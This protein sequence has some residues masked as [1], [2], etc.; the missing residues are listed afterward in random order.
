MK[1]RWL[2]VP[3]MLALLAPH[4][5]A[6]TPPLTPTLSPSRG[7]GQGEGELQIKLGEAKPAAKGSVK[8]EA[9][10][11]ILPEMDYVDLVYL[12][13]DR[14]VLLRLHLR[15]N[16]R[17]YTDRWDKYMRKLYTHLDKNDDG[18][19]T[20]AE[21]E[22][23]PSI[24]FLQ[25]HLGGQI[26]LPYQGSAGRMAQFDR[27]N[28]GKVSL[29]EFKDYYRRSAFGPLQL[30]ST[31]NTPA[32]EAATNSIFKYLD[33]NKDG[34]LSADEVARAEAALHRFDLDENEML[35][36]AELTPGGGDANIFFNPFQPG[37]ATL[38][39]KV[40]FLEVRRDTVAVV[41]QQIVRHYDSDDNGKL[42]RGES[43]L[44]KALFDQLDANRDG[45]L[46]AKELVAFLRRNA[47]LEVIGRIGPLPQEGAVL[48]LLHRSGVPIR[49]ARRADIFNPSQRAMPLAKA[50]QRKDSSAL[51][52]KLGD[53]QVR[54]V[55]GADASFGRFP[56][57]F[58][59]NQFRQAD[60]GNKGV[61]D[62]KQAQGTFVDQIFDLAD[63]NGDGKLTKKELDDY[64]NLQTEGAFCRIAFTV[65]DGGRNLFE[66]L[67]ANRDGRLS[68][69]ELRSAWSRMKP[70]AKSDSGLSKRDIVRRLD[71]SVG[72]G[73]PGIRPAPP[74]GPYSGRGP[75]ARRPNGAPLWFQKMDRNQD[76]DVS[77][78]EFL[79]EEEDFRKLDADGDG[80]ISAEEAQRYGER[81]KK[82]KEKK[83]G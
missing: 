74:A 20:R 26:G 15:N 32:A 62:R 78:R 61:L 64:L 47:D 13:S 3:A 12:A 83:R 10:P 77:P 79:G 14:P 73:E 28:D 68:L 72:T 70:L 38:D 54:L 58:F 1:M 24:Q 81:I 36:T 82:E 52:F 40:G 76:G 44:D 17:P 63:R 69:R 65:T 33:A 19:L 75:M 8:G 7:R 55:V 49:S 31:S 53:A 2:I 60:K 42:D 67:D 46:D 45:Q 34:K 43:G 4:A 18:V 16:G 50:V 59:A 39:A 41:A 80:L 37:N 66:V 29:A 6:Q 56:R 5:A 35:T 11:L 71:L 30:S 21:V 9:K 48:S 22:R 51:G 25:F 27:D 23:A 57:Q